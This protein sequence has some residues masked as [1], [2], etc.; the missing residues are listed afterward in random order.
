[1]RC[2]ARSAARLPAARWTI[3]RLTSLATTTLTSR[4]G[5]PRA[6]RR[7]GSSCVHLGKPCCGN[8]VR[9]WWW[10]VRLGHV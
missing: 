10:R 5:R 7:L 8:H 3:S 6:V 4:R 9:Q 2:S 1:M